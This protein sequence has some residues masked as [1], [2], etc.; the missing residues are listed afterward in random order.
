MARRHSP[1][2]VLLVAVSLIASPIAAQ[3][4]PGQTAAGQ[5]TSCVPG[6]ETR[7]CPQP[8][9]PSQPPREG[10]KKHG[11]GWAWLLILLAGGA[12]AAA[13]SAND[14]HRANASDAVRFD[15]EK[16]LDS[17][18]PQVPKVVNTGT[19]EVEGYVQDGWPLVFNVEAPEGGAI[20]LKLWID[21]VDQGKLAPVLL[22][23]EQPATGARPQR[24][25]PP[26]RPAEVA[27]HGWYARVDLH[28]PEL[29][30]P[31]RAWLQLVALQDGRL[32]P[33]KVYAVGAGP[34][35]VGSTALT[36]DRF[37]PSPLLRKGDPRAANFL[38][39]FHNQQ[40][41]PQLWGRIWRQVA[42][43]QGGYRRK[44]IGKDMDLAGLRQ[45]ASAPTIAGLWPGG[46]TSMPGPGTYDMHVVL[47]T[48]HGDWVLGVSPNSVTIQ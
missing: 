21:G 27:A 13:A 6:V 47:N 24:A 40:Q 2:T 7:S 20:Y 33:L 38:V 18:G 36:V 43:E 22:T 5:R 19:F 11:N 17:K 34:K 29:M 15:S 45:P 48:S 30:E 41:F 28:L 32:K 4:P 16:L 26:P 1:L 14:G 39:R 12:A 8:T 46:G 3:I 31:R 42:V 10:G 44:R 35:A 25:A 37:G 9:P 23:R